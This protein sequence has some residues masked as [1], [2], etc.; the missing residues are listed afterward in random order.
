[1]KMYYQLKFGV[2]PLNYANFKEAIKMFWHLR[3][4]FGFGGVGF[5]IRFKNR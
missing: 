3:Q 5:R 2:E 1:M 4:L